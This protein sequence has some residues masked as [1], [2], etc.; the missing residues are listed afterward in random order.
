MGNSH[1]KNSKIYFSIDVKIEL[2]NLFI[3]KWYIGKIVHFPRLNTKSFYY[4]ME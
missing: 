3:M 4:V 1:E 2:E